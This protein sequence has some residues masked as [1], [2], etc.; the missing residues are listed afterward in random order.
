M[1]KQNHIP[2]I[3]N[4]LNDTAHLLGSISTDS[5]LMTV[6]HLYEAWAHRNQVFLFGNG[7]SA[8]TASHMAN[9]LSKATIVQGQPRMRVLSLTDNVSMITAWANDTSYDG[10]FK[11][12]LA[13]L[14]TPGDTVLAISASG[15]SRN[16]LSA[17]DFA[18][19]NGAVT[20]G[21]TGQSGGKLKEMVNHCLQVPT[22]D[23]GMIE[24]IHL[25]LDHLVANELY[26]R[27]KADSDTKP[28]VKEH[29]VLEEAPERAHPPSVSAGRSVS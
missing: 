9:D 2:S 15:H 1:T 11:E 20:I 27:I 28:V 17:V 26:A 12:Q 21:W 10:V 13:N 29:L 16:V 22:D 18:R 14:L 19:Q 25:V 8:S 7:G 4:Y 23:V 5:I 6:S 24:S 3:T